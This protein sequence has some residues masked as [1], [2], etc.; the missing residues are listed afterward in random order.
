[1]IMTT[2]RR[3]SRSKRKYGKSLQTIDPS[4]EHDYLVALSDSKTR[5]ILLRQEFRTNSDF[6]LTRKQY[7]TRLAT[8][9]SL[10][11]VKKIPVLIGGSHLAVYRRTEMG[12]IMV[13]L[14]T[15][16]QELAENSWR[17]TS[18]DSLNTAMTTQRNERRRLSKDEQ[19]ELYA[20][21]LGTPR[22]RRIVRLLDGIVEPDHSDVKT[23]DKGGESEK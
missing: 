3:R 8:L 14:L 13:K 15:M 21:L 11:L 10:G 5:D 18:L 4:H 23:E 22:L 9:R 2:E 7:Y 20:N 12:G 6:N 17:F 19:K 1:M 16:M